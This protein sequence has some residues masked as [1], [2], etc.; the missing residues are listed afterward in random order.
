MLS[1]TELI[2]RRAAPLLS[3]ALLLQ[4][5]ACHNEPAKSSPPPTATA[6]PKT[7]E[8][9]AAAHAALPRRIAGV[10]LGMNQADVE[11]RLGS[12]RCRERGAELHVCETDHEQIESVRHLEVYIH[13]N[14]VISLAYEIDAPADAWS[15]LDSQIALYGKPSLTNQRSRDQVGHDHE[16]FGWRDDASLYSVRFVW[17]GEEGGERRLVGTAISL[18]DRAAYQTWEDEA[19]REAKRPPADPS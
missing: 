2:Q 13:H 1:F 12:L 10:S 18:W 7:T 17:G 8:S 19:E 11:Q 4:L 15:Y 3:F 9:S 6:P 16:I 5:V 14:R